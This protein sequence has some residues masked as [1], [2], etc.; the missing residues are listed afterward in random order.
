M[1]KWDIVL[2]FIVIGGAIWYIGS[3]YYM[4]PLGRY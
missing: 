4:I 1:D 2:A 3:L